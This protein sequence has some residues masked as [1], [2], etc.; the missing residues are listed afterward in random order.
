MI[1]TVGDLVEDVVVHLAGPVHEA[2]DTPASVVRR[3]GGSAANM[4]VSVVRAGHPA[5]FIGQVGDDPQGAALMEQLRSDGVDVVAR[6]GGATGTIVVLLDHLGERT[7]LTDRGACTHLDHPQRSWLDGLTTLHVPVYSLMGEPLAHT[8]A[9]LVTWAH[10]MGITV[11]IDASSASVINDFGADALI[12]LLSTLQPSVLLCNEMEA[13]ALGEGI[14]PDAIGARLTI[15]KHG[16]S[17]A[18]VMQSGRA[19]VEVPALSLENVRDTTGAG[20]A[21]A[22]GF[23]VALAGG[24]SPVAAT[25]LG[26]HSAARAINLA[27]GNSVN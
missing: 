2:T 12:D 3:R 25:M 8:T 27:S 1:G 15:V 16:S 6:R 21:F 13:E 24:S 26:H 4:A 19:D 17:P 11:S 5:R 9:T 20:D 18:V 7:M 23:L 22:A 14:E 10:E